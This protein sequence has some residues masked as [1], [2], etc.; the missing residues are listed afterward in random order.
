MVS[1]NICFQIISFYSF[2][3][4][5]YTKFSPLIENGVKLEYNDDNKNN[6]NNNGFYSS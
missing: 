1:V 6:N 5:Q 2:I 4:L 3:E